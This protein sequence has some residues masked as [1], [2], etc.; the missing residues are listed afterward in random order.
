M[1]GRINMEDFIRKVLLVQIRKAN[2]NDAKDWAEILHKSYEL[3]YSE[4]ISKDYM[5]NNYSEE[6]LKE[7][8]LSEVTE[9][10][11][12]LELYMLVHNGIPVGILKIGKP[13]KYYT[14]GKEYYKDN[15]EG[16]GEI[17]TLHVKEEYQGH[18]IG[19]QAMS[20]AENKLKEL[21]YNQSS[22]WVKMQNTKAINFYSNR[23][24][25]KTEFIN[26]HT[27]DKAPSMVMEKILRIQLKDDN[28]SKDCECKEDD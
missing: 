24:Y 2:I 12:D 19:S 4:Y 1:K 17:K 16:I 27:N 26:N 13:I 8:F 5:D 25:Q 28:Y 3:T 15:L 10:N 20:F 7:K 22:I 11:S 21:N 14:D 23:G 9:E 6:K 18:G